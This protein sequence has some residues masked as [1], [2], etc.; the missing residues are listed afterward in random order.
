MFP[1]CCMARTIFMLLNSGKPC[2]KHVP[3]PAILGQ[4]K[5]V[6][7]AVPIVLLVFC[8]IA[9]LPTEAISGFTWPSD[10]G[11][12]EELAATTPKVSTEPTAT[13]LSAS[14]GVFK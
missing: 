11:P 10:D 13:T 5:E 7:L 8:T 4:A 12:Y 6:P 1:A 9:F 14:A 2:H 3:K